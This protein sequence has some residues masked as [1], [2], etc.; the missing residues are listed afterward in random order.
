MEQGLVTNLRS[1][2]QCQFIHPSGYIADLD[3]SSCFTCL[4]RH[5]VVLNRVSFMSQT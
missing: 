2:K 5:S 1:G 4:L 3:G